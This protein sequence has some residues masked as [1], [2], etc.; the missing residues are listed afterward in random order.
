MYTTP[1]NLKNGLKNTIKRN[2]N[3]IYL[4]LIL[5]LSVTILLVK[6]PKYIF[7]FENNH[8][9]YCYILKK[10]EKWPIP[11]KPEPKKVESNNG[12][13]PKDSKHVNK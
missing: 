4:K 1:Q 10:Q 12:E 2:P 11:P 13:L 7:K 3:K 8:F 6:K 5:S 9:F